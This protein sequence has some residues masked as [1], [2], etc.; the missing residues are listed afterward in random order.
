MPQFVFHRQQLL[1]LIREALN[2]SPDLPDLGKEFSALF[3]EVCLRANDLM[4]HGL[5]MNIEMSQVKRLL[6]EFVTINDYATNYGI[7]RR[8]ARTR[9]CLDDI[10]SGP[11][12]RERPEFIDIPQMFAS[13]TGFTIREYSNLVLGI[14]TKYLALKP[15]D[16]HHPGVMKFARQYF[17]STKVAPN[18]LDMFLRDISGTLDEIRTDSLKATH[19]NDFAALRSKPVLK[20][21]D[22]SYFVLDAAL[23][24]DKLEAGVFWRVHN[25]CQNNKERDN[26][27]TLWGHVFQQYITQLL[28]SSRPC[29][30]F[31]SLP[32]FAGGGSEACD[33]LIIYGSTV[34]LMEYK[35]SILTADAKYSGSPDRLM[36]DIDKKF[37]GTEESPK[38]IRQLARTV[39]RWGAKRTPDRIHGVE[40]IPRKVFPVIIARESAL[41][42][43][44]MNRYLDQQFSSLYQ[45]KHIR[46]IV[47]PLFILTVDELEQIAPYL[48]SIR[49]CDLLEAKYSSDPSQT[50]PFSSVSNHIL[51]GLPVRNNSMLDSKANNIFDHVCRDLFNRPFEAMEAEVSEQ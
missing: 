1:F 11:D 47:T 38:G 36:Q 17:Q 21:A 51:D 7:L 37:I 18:T 34:I 41:G 48:D 39:S 20:A 16:F 24:A 26:L 45:R 25:S 3:A 31:I 9:I 22:D 30:Q 13:A 43:P 23:V 29:G 42:S 32:H 5:A 40:C 46:P 33:G 2:C 8:T 35:G 12:I 15:T 6:P 27:H 14:L 10:L 4:H 49:L 50:W 28:K 19:L 44:F